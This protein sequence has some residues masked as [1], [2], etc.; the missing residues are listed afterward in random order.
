MQH[1]QRQHAAVVPSHVITRKVNPI[2]VVI[3]IPVFCNSFFSHKKISHNLI[4]QRA[5]WAKFDIGI[6]ACLD[7]ETH[8]NL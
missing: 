6:S 3:G 7:I 5:A 8:S 1:I 4:T 2:G